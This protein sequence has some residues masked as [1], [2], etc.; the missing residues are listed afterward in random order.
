MYILWNHDTREVY[1]L[2]DYP[3]SAVV[4]ATRRLES[5]RPMTL[6]INKC[7]PHLG[8]LLIYSDNPQSVCWHI[9]PATNVAVPVG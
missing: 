9:D 7:D 1:G 5:G 3:Q 8:A 2:H 4:E 6:C